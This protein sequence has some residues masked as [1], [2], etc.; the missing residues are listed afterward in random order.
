[1]T[2][3]AL[4]RG[5]DLIE[6]ISILLK[7][8][9]SH[10]ALQENL[11]VFPGKRPGHFL[12]RAIA[13]A[14]KG[15]YLP[16]TIESL[17]EFIDRTYCDLTGGGDRKLETIDAVAFLFEIHRAMDKPMGGEGFL[18][19][20]TF[21]SM[22]LRI[23]SDL[24]ELMMEDVGKN[25]LSELGSSAGPVPMR[26]E[27]TLRSLSFFYDRFYSLLSDAGYSSRSQRY[28]LVS[29][30]LSR[31]TLQW[32]RIV[33]AGFAEWTSVEASLFKK[34]LEWDGVHFVFQDGATI[35]ERLG[36]LGIGWEP[37][38]ND[39]NR[40]L[41]NI[42]FHKSPDTHGQVFVLSNILREQAA[43]L[44]RTGTMNT[45][46]LERTVVVLPSSGTLFALLYHALPSIGEEPYN[47][48]LGF[49]LERTPTWGFLSCLFRLIMSM[50]GD[51]VY[52]PDYLSFVLHP[53]T[54]N[55]YF[56]GRPEGTRILFHTIEE[57]LTEDSTRTFFSLKEIE[58][59]PSIISEIS[60][61]LRGEE[62]IVAP[63]QIQEQLTTIHSVF[64]RQL[65]LFE[66]VGSFAGRVMDILT[67]VY[68]RS[69]A[70]LHPL[71]HPFAESF[72]Q[73]L[74]A[75]RQSR[76]KNLSFAEKQGYFHFLRRYVSHCL[77]PFEGTPLTGLQILGFLETRNIAFD[78][79]YI[80]DAN[81]GVVPDTSRDNTFIPFQVRRRMGLPTHKEKEKAQLHYLRDLLDHSKETHIFYVENSKKEKS[82]FVERLLWERQLKEKSMSTEAYIS[83]FGYNLSLEAS[84]P[85]PVP[86]TAAVV[87]WLR[88]RAFDATALDTYLRCPLWFFY[89]YVL[90]LSKKEE[91]VVGVERI[92]IGR[93]IHKI[94]FVYF[95]TRQQVT[96]SKKDMGVE[97]MDTIVDNLFVQSYGSDPV[98]SAF[99]LKRQVLLRM[100]EFIE[101][102]ML[103]LVCSLPVRII[104]LERQMDIIIG[105]KRFRGI[106]DRVDVR[107]DR[108]YII[109]Y[110]TGGSDRRFAI[111]YEQVDLCNRR[112]WTRA[113]G[114]IQLPLYRLLY[115]QHENSGTECIFLLLGKAK[116]DNGIELPLFRE[117]TDQLLAY[118]TLKHVIFGLVEEIISP[119]KPF[120]PDLRAVDACRYCDFTNL[121]GTRWQ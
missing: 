51:K 94:M 97:E 23:F 87:K 15:P 110:K 68:E 70:R 92:D 98:G 119:D 95:S 60:G 52:I 67:F 39:A 106:L 12:R 44:R 59:D 17:E 77:S 101:N 1:M 40:S 107:G 8:D 100:R 34:L 36:Y 116:L 114:S 84:Q 102:Y 38:D 33:F 21:F 88:G 55:V 25:A 3:S 89:K 80:L 46:P 112:S 75:L 47:I 65:L 37:P 79:V 31:E 63:V 103:P 109:D 81:E 115:E 78:R 43:S 56:D 96:L 64:I 82:R 6:E 7:E 73:H 90:G 41:P 42:E 30:Q 48:S 54:K 20:E 71:F 13:A 76:I 18:S 105:N 57:R 2:Y 66:D 121:C 117:G 24:E 22:G 99:V 50:D 91:G 93:L 111:N 19:L 72:L 11:V 10:P 14:K 58:D 113:V 118:E 53:Y 104:G 28:R 26:T 16:P 86:K 49:P 61:R 9:G 29:E 62:A 35:R 85:K 74:D 69:S 5:R 83:T 27:E 4:P 120:D 108:T 45:P 32:K